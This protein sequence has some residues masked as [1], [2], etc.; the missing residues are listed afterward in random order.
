MTEAIL[1]LKNHIR[2]LYWHLRFSLLNSQ[3]I[4]TYA[5]SKQLKNRLDALECSICESDEIFRIAFFS[6]QQINK[7]YCKRCHHI[8]SRDLNRNPRK[9]AQLF[10]YDRPNNQYEGQKRLQIE[11]VKNTSVSSGKYL[12]FGVGGNVGISRDLRQLYPQHEF[13]SC[14]LY[15]SNRVDYFQSYAPGSPLHLFDGISSNAV[16]E[17]LDNTFEAWRYLN[18]LLKPMSAGGGIMIHAFPSQI[19]EDPNHWAIKIRSH[20]CLFSKESLKLL[21]QKSGFELIRIKYFASVQH[22][23]YYFR[24]TRDSI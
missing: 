10:A 14:D 6:E 1:R 8:F 22:P 9:A 24:K 15:L 13:Y 20:E 4:R 23:V 18:G 5:L 16:V 12:D 2:P 17:H 21:C 11:L 19:V 3:C 7:C